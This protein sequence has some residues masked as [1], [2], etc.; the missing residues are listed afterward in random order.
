[1]VVIQILPYSAPILQATESIF[2][3]GAFDPAIRFVNGQGIQALLRHDVS[4]KQRVLAGASGPGA[5][6]EADQPA[7]RPGKRRNGRRRPPD[8]GSARFYLVLYAE[9]G[10][11]HVQSCRRPLQQGPFS[12]SPAP[13][14][15]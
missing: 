7:E 3:R 13:R 5:R 1:M 15:L 10:K 8:D 9:H 4:G 14:N 2:T 11:A 6:G 12:R